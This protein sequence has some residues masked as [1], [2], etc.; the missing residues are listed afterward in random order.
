[1]YF[2]GPFTNAHLA[3]ISGAGSCWETWAF[4]FLWLLGC[5]HWGFR[6]RRYYTET[7]K[8]SGLTKTHIYVLTSNSP[9]V[10][11][12]MQVK[13]PLPAPGAISSLPIPSRQ[14]GRERN[15]GPTLSPPAGL[16]PEI[17]SSYKGSKETNPYVSK[18]RTFEW[19][20]CRHSSF[21]GLL[22][23]AAPITWGNL[24]EIDSSQYGWV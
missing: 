5:V 10:N 9:E 15:R 11:Q 7:R 22:L 1:M 13:L 6:L 21:R 16:Y 24:S 14:G 19:N 20:L 18:Q 3:S 17:M 4:T 8:K 12:S 23:Y 2:Y